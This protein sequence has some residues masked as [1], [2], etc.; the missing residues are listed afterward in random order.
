MRDFEKFKTLIEG[1]GW[2]IVET[3]APKVKFSVILAGG[4]EFLF[5]PLSELNDENLQEGVSGFL[6][7]GDN[8]L[9]VHLDFTEN[10]VL[11]QDLQEGKF[12]FTEEDLSELKKLLTEIQDL[13]EY[14]GLTED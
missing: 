13:V 8:V 3:L 7:T 10:K 11:G 6:Y 5:I 1:A 9:A 14:L 12:Y 4:K 2:Y